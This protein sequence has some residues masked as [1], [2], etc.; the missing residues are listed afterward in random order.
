MKHFHV[1]TPQTISCRRWT[2]VPRCPR[3]RMPRLAA[4]GAVCPRSPP[5]PVPTRSR[6]ASGAQAVP[7]GTCHWHPELH[8]PPLGSGFVWVFVG[9]QATLFNDDDRQIMTHFL[10]PNPEE[11]DTARATWQHSHRYQYGLGNADRVLLRFQFRGAGGDSLAAAPGGGSGLRSHGGTQAH[12]DHLSPTSA[13]LG[14]SRPHHRLY[15]GRR[16]AQEGFRTVYSR[17][18]LLQS[19]PG[20]SRS[21]RKGKNHAV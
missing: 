13:Y 18:R 15:R 3:W 20:V 4:T 5:P 9:P 2:D 12:K 19:L 7:A 16:S 6:G 8:V 1:H 10:S 21:G 11:G 14:R 17:L